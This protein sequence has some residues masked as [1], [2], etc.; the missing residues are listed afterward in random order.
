MD[1]SYSGFGGLTDGC[2]RG[3]D[4]TS[5]TC[6]CSDPIQLARPVDTLA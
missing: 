3:F 2:R 1:R 4:I 6:A 5:S